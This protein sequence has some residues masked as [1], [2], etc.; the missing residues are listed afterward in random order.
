MS[1]KSFIQILL[2]LLIISIVTIVYFKYFDTNK[3]IVEEINSIEIENQEKINR[4]EEKLSEL[5]LKNTELKKI[6]EKK[7]NNSNLLLSEDVKKKDI[8]N[9]EINLK[10]VDSNNKFDEKKIVAE[11]QNNKIKNIK[12]DENKDLVKDIEYNSIDNRG[13][14]FYLLAKSGKSNVENKNILD[15]ISVRGEITSNNRDTIYIVSDFGE[16]NSINSNSKFYDN[17][18]INYQDKQITCKN[19]D[20][21]METNKAIAYNDVIITDPNSEMKA[22]LVEFDLKTKDININPQSANTDIKVVTN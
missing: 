9:N 13:N 3:N 21:N 11:S 18:V 5:E 4:L 20:L 14:N 22:G 1:I 16:F 12:I 10:K 8:E 2:L 7:E 6:I 15:L 17:V 19:F